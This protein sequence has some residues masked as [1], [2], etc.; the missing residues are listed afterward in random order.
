MPLPVLT[1]LL[2]LVLP[3]QW[4]LVLPTLVRPLALGLGC[5]LVRRVLNLGQAVLLLLLRRRQ[6]QVLRALWDLRPV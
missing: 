2:V 1:R 3:Q 4:A 5:S 6:L